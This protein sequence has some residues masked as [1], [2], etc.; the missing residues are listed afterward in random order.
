MQ[1][2]VNRAGDAVVGYYS[3]LEKMSVVFKP[4]GQ[5]WQPRERVAAGVDVAAFSVG[6]VGSGAVVAALNRQDGGVDVVRRSPGGA[7][8]AAH[9][10][11]TGVVGEVSLGTNQAG[12][13]LVSWG[14]TRLY[15][16]Y[17]GHGGSWT[18]RYT[19]SPHLNAL[20]GFHAAVAPG[21]D[22]A[23]LWDQKGAALKARL[24]GS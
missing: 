17:L 18:P 7:W 6:I 1:L 10:L 23:V 15:A 19:V 24:M 12:D 4:R 8:S 20:V 13:V 21:G 2:A 14:S 9:Q 11:D 16:S 22:A 3:G 5:A